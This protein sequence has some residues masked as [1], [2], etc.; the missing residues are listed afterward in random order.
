MVL[1]T[2]KATL[3]RRRR[4]INETSSDQLQ[5]SLVIG[6]GRCLFMSIIRSKSFALG[7]V[8]PKEE[9]ERSLSDFL[10]VAAVEALRKHK[11]EVLKKHLVEFKESESWEQY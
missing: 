5:Q 4:N 8:L 10:R 7:L 3:R 1:D 6:D 9:Q 11:E 2:M